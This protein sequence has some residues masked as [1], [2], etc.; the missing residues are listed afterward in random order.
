M[1]VKIKRLILI[2]TVTALAV[3]SV[4][5]AVLYERVESY[6]RAALYS[7]NQAFETAVQAA[8]GMSRALAKSIYATD[9]SMCAR[10]CSEIYADALTAESAISILPFDTAELE[11]IS[12]FLNTAGDYAYTLCCEASEAG[13]TEEQAEALHKM[14][15]TASQLS[16]KLREFQSGIHNGTSV[17]DEMQTHLYNVG[18]D[19]AQKLSASMLEYE[20]EFPKSEPLRYDGQY[21]EKKKPERGL[22]TEEEMRRRAAMAAGVEER[23]LRQE[24]DYGGEDMRRC[25]SAGDMTIIVSTRYVESLGCSRLVAGGDVTEAQARET[26]EKFLKEQGFENTIFS[27]SR[28]NG[29]VITMNYAAAQDDVRCLDNVLTVSVAK[30]DGRI[31]AFNA[32]AYSA[33]PAE[34]EWNIDEEQA[35]KKIPPEL[36]ITGSERVIIQSDGKL[37]VPCFVFDCTDGNNKSVKIYVSADKG[38]QCRIEI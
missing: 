12:A 3:L 23:E 16:D 33:E 30:D 10:L 18:T 13:F 5:S 19:T 8:D 6:G 20:G 37:N 1:S 29:G 9:G 15:A 28:D 24:Y 21:T 17:M 14:S 27:G 7:S 31:Y 35:R 22:L 26:A 34:V 2:Y 36:E 38:K 4:L 25:Y 11:Q 32:A